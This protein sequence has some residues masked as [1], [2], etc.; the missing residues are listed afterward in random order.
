MINQLAK[1]IYEWNKLQGWYCIKPNTAEK[2]ALIH[3]EVS[4][5]LEADR[6][7]RYFQGNTKGIEGWTSE[8]D[9]KNAYIEHCKGTFE[10][11]LADIVIRV[12]DL[13]ELKGI[14]LEWHI[15]AKMRYNKTRAFQ[16]GGKKY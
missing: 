5:A 4:E 6:N 3:S 1:E 11:E 9:F 7:G 10:E 12:L 15:T 16:H 13:A 8:E 2:L 14:N